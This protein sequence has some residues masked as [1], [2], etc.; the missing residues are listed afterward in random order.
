MKISLRFTDSQ[1]ALPRCGAATKF[2]MRDIP[3][4]QRKRRA[5]DRDGGEGR[6]RIVPVLS[7]KHGAILVF[8]DK[9][10]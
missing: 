1:S 10:K 7:A 5:G 9:G 3:R 4:L 8:S 2:V 6:V